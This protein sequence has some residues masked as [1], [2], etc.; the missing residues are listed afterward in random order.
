MSISSKLAPAVTGAPRTP[1]AHDDWRK[2][3]ID[4]R[5]E[6]LASVEATEGAPLPSGQVVAWAEC[7]FGRTDGLSAV[8]RA[9]PTVGDYQRTLCGDQIPVAMMRVALTPNL[10]RTL[11]R[12]RYCEAVYAEEG[13]A[14]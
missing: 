9:G 10:I 6:A 1:A 5:T 2:L 3:E 11:G 4:A 7:R 12:C 8:H 13:V 14:A